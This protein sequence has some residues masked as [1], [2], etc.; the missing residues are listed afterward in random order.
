MRKDMDQLLEAYLTDNL[1]EDEKILFEGEMENDEDLKIKVDLYRETDAILDEQDWEL[2]PTNTSN[3]SINA[4]KQFLTEEQGQQTKHAILNT[5]DK[6]FEQRDLS[7]VSHRS[8][9]LGRAVAAGFFI[10][11]VGLTFLFI[12]NQSN[13]ELYQAYSNHQDLPSFVNRDTVTPL[14]EIERLYRQERY[15]EAMLLLNEYEKNYAD[16]LNPQVYLYIGNMQ[17]ILN[18]EYQALETFNKLRISKTLDSDKA[19]W[20]SAMT[21]LKLNDTASAIKEL[22]KLIASPSKFKHSEALDLLDK[23]D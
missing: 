8:P 1:S 23:L 2:L 16:D 7:P 3:A 4:Y 22:E 5:A 19:Y 10:L 18:Q 11:A 17:M 12:N 6:Y 20:Y 15:D 9:W 13:Y 21:Y 14:S